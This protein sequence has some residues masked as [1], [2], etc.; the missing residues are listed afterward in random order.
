MRKIGIVLILVA[1]ILACGG[2]DTER[3]EYLD[4]LALGMDE[5]I[6]AQDAWSAFN[7]NV[8][9]QGFG[10]SRQEAMSLAEEQLALGR[11]LIGSATALL[12]NIQSLSVP[13]ECQALHL[14]TVEAVQLVEKAFSF[15]NPASE[16]Q[17]RGVPDNASFERGNRL[18]AESDR[19][20]QRAGFG[21]EECAL[22]DSPS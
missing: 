3:T 9:Q 22:G 17:L 13:S 15:L 16:S 18:L 21:I 14:A 6:A 1:L 4:S 12:K 7:E 5:F 10:R 19:A 2:D 11:A 8:A 20:K